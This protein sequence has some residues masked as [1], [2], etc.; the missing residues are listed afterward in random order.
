MEHFIGRK[1]MNIDGLGAETVQLLFDQG[2]VNSSVD[3]YN[4]TFDQLIS[5]ER[6]AEKS[7]NNLLLGLKASKEVPF[8]RVL[9][10]LGIRFVGETVAKKLAKSFKSIDNI[11]N[12]PLE[13]LIA[14]DEIGERI[15]QSVVDYFQVEQNRVNIEKFKAHGLQFQIQEK[16]G[17]SDR[18]L[19]KAFVVS[20][21]FSA[22]SR[23]ELKELIESNGGK[24]VSSISKKTDYVVAGENM[25]PAKLQKATELG[26]AIISENEFIQ[27]ISQ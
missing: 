16:E 19:G 7:A 1:A 5:L 26:V 21:V 27:L 6:M 13:S 4:L 24:N 11:I 9:F 14:V 3:L 18:F 15:A 23:D 17:S 12:A 8:E 22:F 10:A 25:G 20:G 2:L